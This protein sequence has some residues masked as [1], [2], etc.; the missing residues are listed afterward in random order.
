[1]SFSTSKKAMDFT[2]ERY[3]PSEHGII[4]YEHLHRYAAA[5]DF[6]TNKAVLDIAS[7]EGYGAALLAGSAKTVIGVDID[8]ESVGHAKERYAAH[9]NLQFEVGSCA[10]IPILT[11]S[12]EVVTSFETIEHHDQHE[13]MMQEI[14]RVLK[15]EGMLII[16]SPNKLTYSDEPNYQNDYHVKELYYQELETLL[17]KYFK[18][19]CIYGQRIASA[20]FL[21]PLE[22]EVSANS[23]LTSFTNGPEGLSQ[24]IVSLRSPIYFLATCSNLAL[25]PIPASTYLEADDD[26]YSQT[27]IQIASVINAERQ[28]QAELQQTQAEFQKAQS[29]LQQTQAE[30]QKAQSELQRTQAEFQKAQ[31]ELQR[32][33]VELQSAYTVIERFKKSKLWKVREL[34]HRYL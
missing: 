5:R 8:S 30:F 10:Q 26:L 19:V 6:C 28:M 3:V 9:D 2:G 32:T 17:G 12:I 1:M 24:S 31:S 33:Q 22:E 15:P 27:V 14:C 25:Q 34:L 16:S 4:K 20:S 29:E 18:H 11:S 13:E 7:G 21:T 23:E